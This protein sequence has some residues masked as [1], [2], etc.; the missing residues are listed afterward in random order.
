MN[1]IWHDIHVAG[2]VQG[3]GFRPLVHRLAVALGCRGWVN[4]GPA[5]V[6][7]RVHCPPDVAGRLV[8]DIRQALPPIARIDSL[9]VTPLPA[10]PTPVPAWFTIAPSR[11]AGD[12]SAAVTDVSPDIAICPECLADI[13]SQPRRTGY[14]LTN[15]TNCGP[16]FTITA[17]LP[18][19]R[20][21]TTM[22]RFRMCDDCRAE[23]TDP[24]NR[25][26]HAQPIACS[27]CGPQYS[28]EGE[29]DARAILRRS[30]EAILD[31]R[32]L[33]VKGL[34][35][36]NIL[37]DATNPSALRRLRALKNRPRKPFAVMVADE[38]TARRYV[39]LDEAE[40]AALTGWRAPIVVCRRTAASL[41]DEVAPGL[42]TL[43]VMLPYM[44]FQH[45]LL[46]AVSRPVAVT[47]ANFPGMPIIADDD[48]AA[49]Y[50]AA[51]SLPLV[52]F[53]RRIHNRVDDSVVRVI[54]GEPRILRR[55]R[56]Y[57]PEPL[58][59]ASI[60]A[61]GVM[62]AG[63]DVTGGWALG[64]G[65][66]IIASQYIGS[67]DSGEGGELFLRESMANLSALYRFTPRVVAVD[68]H[69]GY[70][71]SRLGR[72]MAARSGARV[73]EVW[74]HHAHA[75]AVMAEY[76][77]EGEVLALVLDGTGA[78]PDGTV[79]GSELLRCSLAGFG[80]LAH[81]PYL[82]MPGG[83][84][85]AREP[86]RMAV[87]LWHHLGRPL[88]ELPEAVKA[89]AGARLRLVETMIA[90][91][92]NSPP[93][94]GAGRLW[95]AVAALAG[96]CMEN[97]YEAEAPVILEGAAAGSGAAA[98]LS[99]EFHE[100]FS[101]LW[102]ARV[103]GAARATG[104]NRVVLTGGVM[105]NALLASRLVELMEREGL[106]VYMPRLTP[107][108]DGAI[109]TGQIAVAAAQSAP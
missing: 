83:D 7:I 10:D 87:A 85:A 66:D 104:L 95:D 60:A 98:E 49:D 23:Y 44:G 65:T 99:R 32:L 103:A 59:T 92:V 82:A 24:S 43:G 94:C 80:R 109:A 20:P 5:G 101:T 90:R 79:W 26:F 91:G 93:S 21:V 28:M 33:M 45:Q 86:W 107:P 78:G 67:L 47:S 17:S 50:A 31:G 19:D 72:E 38:A 69:P 27:Q 96:L 51:R 70:V 58:K 41:P 73:A 2:V 22:A 42:A 36:Y 54:A 68:A 63:A 15:C 53:N 39:D 46:A 14:Q 61:D 6:N 13:A 34:G 4:N 102:A 1:G 35:G 12:A 57:V 16:R 8:A 105:Q 56:G 76:G 48:E 97:S 81:G 11:E 29:T 84:V 64:R 9:T 37:A 100:R 108:G 77:L 71:S 106:A 62:G 30:A 18:Y 88:A 40:R 75:A 74:H 55:G 3:V 52:T 25:R 89:H